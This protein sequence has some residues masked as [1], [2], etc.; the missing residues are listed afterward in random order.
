MR[1]NNQHLLAA[2]AVH[3]VRLLRHWEGTVPID[4]KKTTV[5]GSLVLLPRGGNGTYEFDVPLRQDPLTI[6]HAVLKIQVAKANP[7]P[8]GHEIVSLCQQIPEWIS[9]DHHGTD[10]DLVKQR[11]LGK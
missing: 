6:P 11:A 5:D 9:L 3:V 2:R 10:A 7:I 8:C 4:P 1:G